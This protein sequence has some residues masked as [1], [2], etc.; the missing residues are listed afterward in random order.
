SSG[1]RSSRK[2][3]PTCVNEVRP[4]MRAVLQRLQRLGGD[5]LVEEHP[6]GEARFRKPGLALWMSLKDKIAGKPRPDR[7]RCSFH[8][9]WPCAHR[10]RKRPGS[11]EVPKAPDPNH[12]V[13]PG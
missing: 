10:H 7:S 3:S 6:G 8:E 4:A 12:T 9:L 1:R 5:G 11:F 2:T 13:E